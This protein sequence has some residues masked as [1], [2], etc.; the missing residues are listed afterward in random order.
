M[1]IDL[2][3]KDVPDELVERLRRRAERSQSSL[4][5][6]LRS[7]LTEELGRSPGRLSVREARRRVAE[8]GQQSPGESATM[9]REDRDAR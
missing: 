2:T 1:P 4:Q 8:L 5:A 6:E 7:I 9:I 3:I